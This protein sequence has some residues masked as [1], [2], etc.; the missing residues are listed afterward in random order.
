MSDSPTQHR[1]LECFVEDRA[2]FR[3]RAAPHRRDWMDDSP[4]RYAYRCLPLA[5]ANTYGWDL[6]NPGAFQAKWDGG[7][8]LDAITIAKPQGAPCH[9][10]TSHFGQGILTFHISCLFRTPPGYDLW[11]MGPANAIRPHI[12]A[13]NAVVETDWSPYTFTMNW[14]FTT[15]DEVVTFAENDPI[16]TIFPIKRGEIETFEP[17]LRRPE[18][19]AELWAEFSAWRK[20]RS[21]FNEELQKPGSE[22]QSQKWQKAYM[23]GPDDPVTPAHRSKLRLRDMRTPDKS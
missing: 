19:D 4:D 7:T 5:I 17:V 11:V 12:Q 23:T 3:I 10:V 14:K 18:E 2:D 16:A 13:L 20:S 15:P 22:A 9:H 21:N 8:G 1:L 6:L